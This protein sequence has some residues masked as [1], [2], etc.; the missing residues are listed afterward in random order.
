MRISVYL[1]LLLPVL[2]AVTTPVMT[3]WLAPK[4]AARVMAITAALAAAASSWTLLL[5]AGTLL[6]HAP[7]AE[8]RGP[9]PHPVPATVAV[10]AVIALMHGARRAFDAVQARLATDRTLRE[11]CQT[12]HPGGELAVV[13]D[14][15]THAYAIPGRPGRILI[16]TG[17]LKASNALDRRVVLAHERAHL[18]QGHHRLRAITEVASALN[19]LLTPACNAVSYLVERAADEAAAE[20]VGSRAITAACLAKIALTHSAP[21]LTPH[22]AFHRLAVTDRVRALQDPPIVS[23]R[24][25]A[26]LFLIAAAL[27]AAAAGDAPIAFGHIV[28]AVMA[29]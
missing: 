26:L 7:E 4:L 8:P 21:A 20:T 16:S 5:L 12:C 23:V 6:Q 27:T 3:R 14:D 29:K 13:A 19:P 18:Q 10:I 2:L 9:Q 17:L 15:G 22:L 28:A 25:V 24:P 11:I 1:P